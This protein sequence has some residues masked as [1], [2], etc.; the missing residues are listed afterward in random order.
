MEC[1]AL[2]KPS[3]NVMH[4]QFMAWSGEGERKKKKSKFSV[5]IWVASRLWLK[6]PKNG[7]SPNP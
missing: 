5:C 3:V 4:H 1:Q 6:V 7:D 2:R